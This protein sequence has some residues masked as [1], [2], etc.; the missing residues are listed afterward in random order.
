[1]E[2]PQ[3][4]AR[5]LLRQEVEKKR[6]EDIQDVGL[7]TDHQVGIAEDMGESLGGSVERMGVRLDKRKNRRMGMGNWQLTG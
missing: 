6:Y 5:L 7:V 2:S 4:I 3:G 1:M